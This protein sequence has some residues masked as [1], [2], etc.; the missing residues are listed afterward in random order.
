MQA[1]R[2]KGGDPQ[3]LLPK[4]ALYMGHVS[5]E[6]TMHYLKVAPQLALVASQRFDAAYGQKFLG[7]EP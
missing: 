7:G 3:A 6:S 4:L 1:Y 5:V 2:K